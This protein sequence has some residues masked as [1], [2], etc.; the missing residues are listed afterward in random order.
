MHSIP[1]PPSSSSSPLLS[2]F[3]RTKS[4]CLHVSRRR[5]RTV[6]CASKGDANGSNYG[7]RMVDENMVVLRKRIHETRMAERSVELPSNWMEWE[8]EYYDGNYGSDVCEIVGLLQAFLMNTR[9]SMAIGLVM[10][11]VMSVPT[12][13]IL[14]LVHLFMR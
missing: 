6:G 8:K 7:G 10:L 14:I 12:S 11:L 1:A 5:T 4:P 13:V 9:P 2:A 3:Q